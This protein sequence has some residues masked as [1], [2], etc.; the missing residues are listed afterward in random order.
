MTEEFRSSGSVAAKFDILYTDDQPER[1]NYMDMNAASGFLSPSVNW[2]LCALN[3]VERASN[4]ILSGS[5][6][7]TSLIEQ[8]RSSVLEM[9]PTFRD[10]M[11]K[12]YG[13]AG[14]SAAAC[15]HYNMA[16]S[17]LVT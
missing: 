5:P 17:R 9:Y 1:S 11:G 10:L 7:T 6:A 14:Q 8:P 2:S 3:L 15:M 12:L 16:A 13:I 4:H